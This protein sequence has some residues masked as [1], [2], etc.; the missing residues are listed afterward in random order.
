MN[1]IGKRG[2]GV[3]L[4]G[5]AAAW[6]T[7]SALAANAPA[8][9]QSASIAFASKTVRDWRPDGDKGIWVQANGNNWYYGAF[10]FPCQG[11]EFKIGVRFLYG[12]NGELDK[13]GGIETHE[14]GRC[15]FKSFET[16][17]GPPRPVK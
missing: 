12:P 7:G 6:L 4:A 1:S 17:A 14:A 9:G 16:S 13:W 2:R 15:R 10:D 5:T 11:L 8:P 3:A